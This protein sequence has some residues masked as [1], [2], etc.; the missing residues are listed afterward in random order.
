VTSAASSAN[1][2]ARQVATSRP[3]KMGA[4]VGIVAYGILH[5][6]IA[7]LALQIAFGQGGQRAD[8]NGAFQTLAQG[9]GGRILLWILVVGFV[10]ACLWRLELAVWGYSYVHD[11][12]KQVRR[13]V[14]SGAK[15]VLFAV[16]AF[17]AG[18][19]ATGGGSSG[20]QQQATAGVLGM[21]GGQFLVGLAGLAI[22]GLGI[23][24]IIRGWKKKFT[25]DMDLPADHKARMLAIR[26]GQ[27][28]YVGRGI[29]T[30]VVGILVLAA[31]IS[32]NPGEAAGLDAALKTLAAQPFG[33]YLLMLVA[34]GFLSFGVF[35]A[36]DA[37]YH[38]V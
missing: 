13:R 21:P 18:R 7:W 36:F 35:C 14:S 16:L 29:V 10:A 31:A 37:R 32:F 20:Q 30:C 9:T 1:Q 2:S 6:L 34:L 3:V 24:K 27:V 22:L 8:Q 33:P 11:T 5:V 15:A 26:S 23:Y 19:T 28:G 25:E 38:R 4:R 12:K 17:L